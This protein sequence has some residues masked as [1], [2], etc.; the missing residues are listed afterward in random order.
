MEYEDGEFVDILDGK[1]VKFII[2][3]GWIVLDGGGIV[4]DME[5]DFYGELVI[6]KSL[7]W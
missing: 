6:I 3:N 5:V 2:R 7:M 1:W 4:L